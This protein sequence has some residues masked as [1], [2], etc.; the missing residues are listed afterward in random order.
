MPTWSPA[1]TVPPDSS[2]ISLVAWPTDPITGRAKS[3]VGLAEH[4]VVLDR[5][6]SGDCEHLPVRGP[7]RI[8]GPE[9]MA[10][11]NA[12]GPASATF[13]VYAL[14]SMPTSR[15]RRRTDASTA[16]GSSSDLSSPIRT[17]GRSCTIGS[18]SWP[19]NSRARRPAGPG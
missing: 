6:R 12:R 2:T 9:T 17:T 8:R 11:T 18:P 3:R 19:S 4:L 10:S 14:A 5:Q 16:A 7:L 15:A 13:F 1:T